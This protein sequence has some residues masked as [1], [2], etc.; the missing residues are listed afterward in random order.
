[1]L[2]ERVRAARPAFEAYD[3]IV[4]LRR[5]CPR[6]AF[7][8]VADEAERLLRELPERSTAPK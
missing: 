4:R 3:V 5:G 1:L 8:A 6:T 2:R 7:R